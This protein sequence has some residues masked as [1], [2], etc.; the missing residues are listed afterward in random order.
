VHHK[1]TPNFAN[2][3]IM[4]AQS[5]MVG[6]RHAMSTVQNPFPWRNIAGV[7]KNISTP[8]GRSF[9]RSLALGVAGIIAQ[10][11]NAE[12]RTRGSETMGAPRMEERCAASA[13]ATIMTRNSAALALN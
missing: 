6:A 12:D 2:I 8:D 4:P 7:S 3:Q 5:A 13:K 10:S 1:V 11:G 9:R